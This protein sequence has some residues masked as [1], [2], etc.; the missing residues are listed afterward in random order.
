[1]HFKII[2]NYNA[3]KAFQNKNI[4]EGKLKQWEDYLAGFNVDIIY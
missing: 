2:I 4:L 3:L 1:M